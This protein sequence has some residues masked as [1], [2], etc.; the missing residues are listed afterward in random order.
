MLRYTVKSRAFK[1]GRITI[2]VFF[3]C[4][5]L[6][7]QLNDPALGVLKHHYITKGTHKLLLVNPRFLIY[8]L[9]N[10]LLYYTV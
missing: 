4:I 1:I 5:G 9:L 3:F 7:T 2:F 8:D 10:Q 6:V